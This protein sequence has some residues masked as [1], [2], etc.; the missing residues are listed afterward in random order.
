M[1][2]LTYSLNLFPLRTKAKVVEMRILVNENGKGLK[3]HNAERFKTSSF[4]LSYYAAL[5]MGEYSKCF[6]NFTYSSRQSVNKNSD[7]NRETRMQSWKFKL[8]ERSLIG[9]LP[10]F[11]VSNETTRVG[12]V[13]FRW[14]NFVQQAFKNSSQ[15]NRI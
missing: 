7:D 14:S 12:V 15:W 9:L 4:C 8:E 1:R 10:V 6:I 3:S 13:F 11:G 2:V 5:F